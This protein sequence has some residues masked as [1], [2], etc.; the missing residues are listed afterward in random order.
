MEKLI[1]QMLARDVAVVLGFVA[2]MLATM[3]FLFYAIVV[4]VADATHRNVILAVGSVTLLFAGASLLVL[5]VHLRKHRDAIYAEELRHAH[6]QADDTP[7]EH[8]EAALEDTPTSAQHGGA[9]MKVF[10]IVFIMVLCFVT[11]L[12][13]MILRGKTVNGADIYRIEWISLA[14]TVVG[15]VLYFLYILHHSHNELKVMVDELYTGADA[16]KERAR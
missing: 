12:A 6:G 9:F 5:I 15:F 11:L 13:T 2:F 1:R 16:E 4:A 14:V 3:G 10:D 7:A 8:V